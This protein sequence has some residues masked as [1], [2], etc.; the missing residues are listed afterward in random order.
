MLLKI[1]SYTF[2]RRRHLRHH[3]QL[4]QDFVARAENDPDGFTCKVDHARVPISRRSAA[5][6]E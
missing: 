4:E 2:M 6:I 1:V 3:L 5:T